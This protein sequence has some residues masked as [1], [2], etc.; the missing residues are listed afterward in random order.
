MKDVP[1][2]LIKT[3]LE[4]LSGCYHFNPFVQ[5]ATDRDAS[6]EST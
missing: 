6:R 2:A 5:E 3:L 1:A 4:D